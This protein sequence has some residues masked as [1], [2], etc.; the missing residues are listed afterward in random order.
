M[1]D[2]QKALIM[3]SKALD[4]YGFNATARD[5]QLALKVM[6]AIPSYEHEAVL[7]AI[8]GKEENTDAE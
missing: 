4:V 2:Y 3:I 5:I 6:E 7:A 8:F 1:S